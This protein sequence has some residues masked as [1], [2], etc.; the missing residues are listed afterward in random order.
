MW[1]LKGKLLLCVAVL[2]SVLMHSCFENLLLKVVSLFAFAMAAPL[3]VGIWGAFFILKGVEEL[4]L[5]KNSILWQD[6]PEFR[7][8]AEQMGVK[9]HRTRPFG[10]KKGLDNAFASYLNRQVIFGAELLQKLNKQEKFA[11]AAHELAH[12][13]QIPGFSEILLLFCGFLIPYFLETPGIMKILAS[14][15]FFLILFVLLCWQR[16]FEADTTAA[17]IVGVGTAISLLQ[18]LRP[19]TY[20]DQDSETHP[21]IRR[22]I[23]RLMRLWEG[24]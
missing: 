1:G 8:L 6:M 9:L 20:W 21:S 17:G 5:L 14:F 10:I 22:R 4:R 23:C 16:E 24:G 3:M 11:L 7:I 15:A 19:P 2:L 12:L 18:K 13:K